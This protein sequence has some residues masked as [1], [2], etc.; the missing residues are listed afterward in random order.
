MSKLIKPKSM[1]T[2]VD[3]I[4]MNGRAQFFTSKCQSMIKEDLLGMCEAL[5]CFHRRNLHKGRLLAKFG[6]VCVFSVSMTIERKI[7]LIWNLCY[8]INQ[9]DS[10]GRHIPTEF[11]QVISNPTVKSIREFTLLRSA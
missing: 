11:H 8:H 2:P 7:V 5:F 3:I 6:W 1:F 9:Q 4:I 10:V